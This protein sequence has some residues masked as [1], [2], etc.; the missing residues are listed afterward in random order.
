MRYADLTHI[1][2]HYRE[3]GDPNGPAL[4]FS[5]SLGTD[6]RLWDPILPYLPKDFRIIRYD[7]RGHG[8]SECPSAP[9]VWAR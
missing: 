7:K 4:V 8:L 5:N 2:L 1:K 9:I 6:L 3:D